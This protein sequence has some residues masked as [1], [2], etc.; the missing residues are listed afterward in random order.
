MRSTL[1]LLSLALT[2]FAVNTACS[3]SMH[4]AIPHAATTE[5]WEVSAA[6]A[7]AGE[8]ARKYRA[9]LH[10]T[11]ATPRGLVTERTPFVGTVNQPVNLTRTFPAS[12]AAGVAVLRVEVT[13]AGADD[14]GR[15][16]T[17]AEMW[18]T[19]SLP[20]STTMKAKG[21][22]RENNAVTHYGGAQNAKV[23]VPARFDTTPFISDS[24]ADYP[25]HSLQLTVQSFDP[26]PGTL[27]E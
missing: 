6:S 15:Y 8:P 3:R 27:A 9:E 4:A 16:S 14:A 18:R 24:A 12:R 7:P 21:F 22:P 26:I 25:L 11:V 23:G 13:V 10:T 1:I 2:S 5:Q 17:R 19:V 20:Q